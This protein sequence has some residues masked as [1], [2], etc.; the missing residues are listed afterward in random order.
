MTEPV[1]ARGQGRGAREV[2]LAEVQAVQAVASERPRGELAALLAAVG[3]GELGATDAASCSSRCSSSAC[4]QG[5]SAPYYGPGGEQAALEAD[6]RLPRGSELGASAAAVT[7]RLAA[8]AGKRLDS[9]RVEATA[10]GQLRARA[11]RSR[12]PTSRSGSIARAPG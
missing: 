6:R 12:A 8:I 11:R 3:E 2:A 1:G 9:V 5:A 10:A 4:R 7:R